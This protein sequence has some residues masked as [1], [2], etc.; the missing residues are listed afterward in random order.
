MTTD[1]TK[2]TPSDDDNPAG[3]FVN[4]EVA[5]II[6]ME[7]STLKN[8]LH[9]WKEKSSNNKDV[10]ISQITTYNHNYEEETEIHR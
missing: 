4:I 8:E 10:L 1:T 5:D 3:V 7:N 9:L 2:T 6:K